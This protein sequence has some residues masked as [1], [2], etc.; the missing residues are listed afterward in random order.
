MR[1]TSIIYFNLFYFIY[2]M[3]IIDDYD[4]INLDVVVNYGALVLQALFHHWPKALQ[5]IDGKVYVM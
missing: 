5:R 1:L 3:T 2:F 4:E